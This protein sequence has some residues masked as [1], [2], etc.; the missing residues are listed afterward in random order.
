MKTLL[1]TLIIVALL[2]LAGCYV[3]PRGTGYAVNTRDSSYNNGYYSNR[4][5]YSN[6]NGYSNDYHNGY[7]NRDRPI[8]DQRYRNDY[9]GNSSGQ[10]HQD[11][12]HSPSRH[13]RY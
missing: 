3:Q 7:S 13:N 6:H 1:K 10:Y 2:L 9:H 8:R 5:G 11:R 12:H 4:N